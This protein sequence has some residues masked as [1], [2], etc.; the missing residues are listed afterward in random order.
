MPN[1]NLDLGCISDHDRPMNA[2]KTLTPQQLRKAADL[3][4]QIIAV[5]NELNQ[6][7]GLSSRGSLNIHSGAHK[8]GANVRVENRQTNP[9]AQP[10]PGVKSLRP[11]GLG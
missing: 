3:Q 10:S 7:L 2:V 4:E 5:R 1:E 6:V 11:V 8:R 9:S